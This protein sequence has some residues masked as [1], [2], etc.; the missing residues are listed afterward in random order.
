[1]KNKK[2]WQTIMYGEEELTPYYFLVRVLQQ[3]GIYYPSTSA[4]PSYLGYLE[5]L[6]SNK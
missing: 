2:L 1:M 3:T 4:K 6:I 5:N